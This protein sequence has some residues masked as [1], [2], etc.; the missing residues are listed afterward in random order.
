MVEVGELDIKI[1]KTSI[2]VEIG[3][4]MTIPTHAPVDRKLGPL[5]NSNNENVV[6][7][8]ST[9]MP[10]IPQPKRVSNIMT[11]IP[12]FVRWTTLI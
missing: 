3:L 6:K 12:I 5:Q 7:R 11:E 8:K 10:A 1:W 2:F 4:Y 9:E